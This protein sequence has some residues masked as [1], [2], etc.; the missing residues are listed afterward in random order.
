MSTVL[1]IYASMSGNTES[2]A[3]LIEEG[4]Q[5]EGVTV[6]KKDVFDVDINILDKYHSIIFGS[7]T[8]G[9]GELPDE[10]LDFYDELTEV[11]LSGKTFAVFG[12]G[13]R[14]YKIYCGAVDIFESAILQQGGILVQESLKIEDGPQDEEIE[15]C[16]LFGR[17]FVQNISR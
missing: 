12:S 6:E 8:W 4:I 9:D 3:D 10:F 2:I 7:Y 14:S 11:D 13:D 5:G 1:I 16:K 15:K 17:E